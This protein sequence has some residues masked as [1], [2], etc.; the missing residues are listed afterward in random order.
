MGLEQVNR[1][2]SQFERKVGKDSLEN[3]N[4]ILLLR[5]RKQGMISKT[6]ENIVP[7]CAF[8]TMYARW[9]HSWRGNG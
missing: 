2:M 7:S 9:A 8:R 4:G 3:Q 5:E 6:I 1:T